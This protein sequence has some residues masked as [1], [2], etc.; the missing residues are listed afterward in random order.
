[1][2]VAIYDFVETQRW[3]EAHILS[4]GMVVFAFAVI[5]TMMVLEKRVGRSHR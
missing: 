4:A 5:T 1:M 2:S 3:T